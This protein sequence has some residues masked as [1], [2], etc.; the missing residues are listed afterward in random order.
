ML[1]VDLPNDVL[2]EVA[3][4]LVCP[5]VS[6][7]L[8]DLASACWPLFTLYCDSVAVSKQEH[9]RVLELCHRVGT[10]VDVLSWHLGAG[11]SNAD[12][13]LTSLSWSGMGITSTDC[14]LIARIIK[15]GC[16][17]ALQHLDLQH[18]NIGVAGVGAITCLGHGSLLGELK[19][20]WL[21]N[22]SLGRW[23]TYVLA[24]NCHGS[25]AM[26]Q[27]RW[28][29]I[30]TNSLFDDGVCVL[31]DAFVKG[32]FPQLEILDLSGNFIGD[33]GVG[34]LCSAFMDGALTQLASMK[35]NDNLITDQGLTYILK[36]LDIDLLLVMMEIML[37]DNILLTEHAVLAA[38]AQYNI[39]RHAFRSE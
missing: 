18:N 2:L 3:T 37:H 16:M 15:T 19:E 20:L 6:S 27:L 32:A 34:A 24:S 36:I 29:D 17:A 1:L 35:L 21:S 7:P 30:S 33:V 8:E 26:E 13:V 22:N 38:V 5:L 12:N 10:S 31:S 28:L 4:W 39:V 14:V 25:R 23:G 11:S 9:S